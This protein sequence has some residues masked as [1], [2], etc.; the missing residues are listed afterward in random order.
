MKP[1]ASNAFLDIVVIGASAGGVQALGDLLPALP[2]DFAPAVVVALHQPSDS[3][4]LFADMFNAKCRLPVQLAEDK[5]PLCQGVVLFAPPGYHTLVEPDFTIALSLDP[6]EHYSRPSVD[7]LFEPG[8]W[9]CRERTLGVLLTGASADGARGLQ[10]IHRAGGS[11]WVQDP[12]TA[13][14]D[15]MPRSALEIGVPAEVLTLKQ[16]SLRLAR[17]TAGHSDVAQQGDIRND[18]E[19]N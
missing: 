17:M 5:Q 3:A 2:E 12:A 13:A 15:T 1:L 9:T 8:A 14:S 10:W 11:A 18:K 7:A 6:P 16:M 4:G 19:T